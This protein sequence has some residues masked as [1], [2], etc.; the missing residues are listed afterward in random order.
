[1]D[2]QT[3]HRCHDG[4]MGHALLKGHLSIMGL[5]NDPLRNQYSEAVES[6]S[7]FLCQCDRF[8]TLR[9]AI[10]GKSY[11]HRTDSDFATV[12]DLVIYIYI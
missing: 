7:H 3:C 8:R 5:T 9:R 11:L 12:S 2:T 4:T 10:W 1:M 6:A